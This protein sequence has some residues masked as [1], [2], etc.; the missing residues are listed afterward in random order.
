MTGDPEDDPVFET[1]AVFD[2]EE[3]LHFYADRVA[4]E[5]SE[6]EAGFVAGALDLSAGDRVLD[7]PCGHGRISNPLAERGIEVAGIDA[8]EGFLDRAR[9]D[10][11]ERGV[12]DR[13]EYVHGDMRHLPWPA[14]SFDAA[15]NAF[16]SFGY[17]DDAGNRRVLAEA[18]RVLEPGGRLLVDVNNHDAVMADFEE[19]SVL[20]VDGDYM[21]DRREYDPRTG[22]ITTGRLTVRDGRTREATFSVRSYTYPELAAR[23]GDAGFDVVAE[24][25]SLEGDDYSLSAGRTVLVGELRS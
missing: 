19:T 10:A 11:R 22:R 24:Y 13:V 4:P 8:T 1:E 9:A 20:E 25:G 5:R 3:Y 12:A 16:T 14:D 17:F 23:F 18:A 2:P 21:V 15:Y 7:V 6:R